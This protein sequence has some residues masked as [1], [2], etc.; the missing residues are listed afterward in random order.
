MYLKSTSVL[1]HFLVTES[2][3]SLVEDCRVLHRGENRSRHSPILLKLRVGDIPTKK[4]TITLKPK[5]PAWT[6]TN[7]ETISNYQMDLHERLAARN[8]PD[9]L[10]CEDPHCCDQGHSTHRDNFM[11]DI[12]CSVIESSHSVIPLSGGSMPGLNSSECGTSSIPGWT[13]HVEP[14]CQDAKFWHA[15]WVSWG[16]PN[17]GDLHVAMARSRNLYHYAVRKAKRQAD[18]FKAK[19]LLE[20]SLTSD[21]ELLK[22]MKKIR[23][24]EGGVAE[25]PDNVA[26]AEGE[27]AIVEKFREVYSALYN[28]ASTAGEVQVIKAALCRII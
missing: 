21:M 19:K 7:E 18:L 12:L 25:L 9:C 20:A 10:S 4:K 6:K 3:L 15:V 8:V 24:G 13:E 11:L 26:G 2:L 28:S 23:S 17:T 14:F 5:K 27:E 22:E 16:K 1:D